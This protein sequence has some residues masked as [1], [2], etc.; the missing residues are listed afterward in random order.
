MY[1]C[2]GVCAGVCARVCSVAAC[3]CMCVH[4]CTVIS[5]TDKNSFH[6]EISVSLSRYK[7]KLGY[8][9]KTKQYRMF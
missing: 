4:A 2:V 9:Y 6:I 8:S 3:A 7:S 1:A 5:L